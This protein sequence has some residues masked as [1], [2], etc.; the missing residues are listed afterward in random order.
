MAVGFS[1]KDKFRLKKKQKNNSHYLTVVQE[2]TQAPQKQTFPPLF[3]QLSPNQR[4]LL[5]FPS[6]FA[7]GAIQPSLLGARKHK[8]IH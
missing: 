3:H 8:H 4:R 2:V 1:P 6:I 5:M 7:A